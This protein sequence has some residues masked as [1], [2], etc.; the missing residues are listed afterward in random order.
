MPRHAM[1][2]SSS[3]GTK[4]TLGEEQEELGDG[5]QTPRL[6][7]AGDTAR[8]IGMAGYSLARL[9][10][11]AGRVCSAPGVLGV[12]FSIAFFASVIFLSYVVVSFCWRQLP[13]CEGLASCS[14]ASRLR[15]VHP[16]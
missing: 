8:Q 11:S 12:R 15:L 5:G 1:K 4:L 13:H 7:R 2:G 9:L 16:C 3:S 14:T 6:P 10:A